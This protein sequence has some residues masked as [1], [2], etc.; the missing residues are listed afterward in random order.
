MRVVARQDE[1]GKWDIRAFQDPLIESGK[2]TNLAR[3]GRVLRG[4]RPLY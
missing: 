1:A 4:F 2:I 3:R